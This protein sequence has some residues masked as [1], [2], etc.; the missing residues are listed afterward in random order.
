MVPLFLASEFLT[1]AL[2]DL[3]SANL[4]MQKGTAKEPVA[5]QSYCNQTGATVSAVW[6][7]VSKLIYCLG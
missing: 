5:L 1:R 4:A 2:H 3:C 6:P 7:C